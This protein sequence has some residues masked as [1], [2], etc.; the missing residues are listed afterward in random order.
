MENNTSNSASTL[1][2]ILRIFSSI[3]LIIFFAFSA[4][5]FNSGRNRDKL[6]GLEYI[7]I[8]NGFTITYPK[9]WRIDRSNSS[10]IKSK[11]QTA[12]SFTNPV[13][14]I[15]GQ[16]LGSAN[17]TVF[18]NYAEG[19][20]NL[21]VYRNIVKSDM[22]HGLDNFDV[23]KEEK[24]IING[25]EG[26]LI[27]SKDDGNKTESASQQKPSYKSLVFITTEAKSNREFFIWA[28][29]FESSWTDYEKLFENCIKSFKIPQ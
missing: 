15:N 18:F 22:S 16:F 3:I 24:I 26:Y 4:L 14:D 23:L 6:A 28:T 9:G 12:I 20:L 2:L 10:L 8:E 13:G 1:D 5:V 27:S 11:N 29:A 19:P 7:D 21:D 25:L 17:F